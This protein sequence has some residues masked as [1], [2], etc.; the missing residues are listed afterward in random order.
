MCMCVMRVGRH[1]VS[2]RAGAGV[3]DVPVLDAGARAAGLG[4]TDAD[5]PALRAAAAHLHPCAP[6]AQGGL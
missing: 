3:A 1:W 5:D 4:R 2:R 6:H